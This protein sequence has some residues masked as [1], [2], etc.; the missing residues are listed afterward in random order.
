MSRPH[1]ERAAAD[2]DP[3]GR[4][5]GVCVSVRDF[6][7]ARPALEAAGGAGGE[8]RLYRAGA[9]RA[10]DHR[11]V[12]GLGDAA[13]VPADRGHDRQAAAR[14]GRLYPVRRR[15]S[16]RDRPRRA[17]GDP[18]GPDRGRRCAGARL[19]AAH[20]A[21][22][23]AA[24][25]G[26]GDP[27]LGQQLYRRLQEHL[28]RHHHRPV[29]PAQHRQ[30]RADR[31]QLAGL[32]HSRHMSSRRRSIGASAFSCRATAR[33]SSASSTRAGGVSRTRQERRGW[34]RPQRR[35]PARR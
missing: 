34:P 32:C 4:R 19:L 7:G 14:P 35:T 31:P 33:C 20:P 3:G 29:R 6:A 15:L 1:L 10:A 13:A 2:A 11:I 21:H 5:H 26:D 17:A 30:Y 23:P 25:L 28:A 12:H 9:R 27:A 8:R 22:C 24:G 18:E 16:R